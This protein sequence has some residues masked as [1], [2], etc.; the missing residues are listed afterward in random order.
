MEYDHKFRVTLVGDM[1][2]GK[3]LLLHRYIYDEFILS[4]GPRTLCKWHYKIECG[5]VTDSMQGAGANITLWGCCTKVWS[6]LYCFAEL[7][8]VHAI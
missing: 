2:V 1:D 8:C 4:P 6:W 7:V 3:T 5:M